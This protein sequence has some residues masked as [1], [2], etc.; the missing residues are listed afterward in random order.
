MK[1]FRLPNYKSSHPLHSLSYLFTALASSD[2]RSPYA[3]PLSQ[4]PP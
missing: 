4:A 1:R 3:F 2:D